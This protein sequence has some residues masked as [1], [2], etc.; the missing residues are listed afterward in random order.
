LKLPKIEPDKGTAVFYATFSI[1]SAKGTSD[2][3]SEI[4]HSRNISRPG[5]K[6]ILLRITIGLVLVLAVASAVA[7]Y[8]EQENQMLRIRQRQATLASELSAAKAQQAEL[9]ELQGIV[10][11]DEY[12][13]RMAR[14]KLGMVKPNEVVFDD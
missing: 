3:M 5:R 8:F 14:E 2:F 7:I 13:E 4:S 6:R 10:D 12:I 1:V 9:D 11:T